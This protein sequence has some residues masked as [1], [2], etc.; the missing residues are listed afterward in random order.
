MAA[1]LWFALTRDTRY[2]REYMGDL[3]NRIVGARLIDDGHSPYFYKYAPGDP[4]RYYDPQAFDIYY[5]SIC[6]STPFLHRLLVPLARLPFA[7]IMRLWVGVLWGLYLAMVLYAMMVARD[8]QSRLIVAMVALLFLF[9]NSWELHTKYGQTYLLVPALAMLVFALRRRPLLAGLVAAVLV[10]IRPNAVLFL[11]PF[12]WM[13]D[14]KWASLAPAVVALAWVLLVPRERRLWSDYQVMLSQQVKIHQ[15]L[16]PKRRPVWIDP[17]IGDWEG[18]NM[19]TVRARIG[20]EPVHIY[21]ENG[22]VF[23]LYQKIVGRRMPLWLLAGLGLLAVAA[24]PAMLMR[25]QRRRRERDR[26]R[27]P[28]SSGEFDPVR[29][30]IIGFCLYMISDLFSPIYRHAY[31]GVQWIMPLL[32]AAA[33]YGEREHDRRRPVYAWLLLCLLLNI[34]HLPFIRMGNTIGEYGFLIGLLAIGFAHRVENQ[35]REI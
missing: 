26:V 12:L 2:S 10:M 17:G 5:V 30:A 3:R 25:V 29:L 4:V 27:S 34:V 20:R 18:I 14:V 11:V 28:V 7:T 1:A 23:V 35:N 8:V 13:R 21:S 9:S 19:D 16:G 24:V 33:V 32:L 6:T 22:N 31:Y 15:D